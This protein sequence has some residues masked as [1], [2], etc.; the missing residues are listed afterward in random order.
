MRVL[1]AI[2]LFCLTLLVLGMQCRVKCIV[3]PHSDV[4]A[5]HPPG[6]PLHKQQVPA[7]ASPEGK[8]CSHAPQWDLDD[9]KMVA[10]LPDSRPC[11]TFARLG[12]VADLSL[13][14]ASFTPPIQTNLRI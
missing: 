10:V 12:P 5:K 13:P 3:I 7:D 11:V 8:Q 4:A 9:V 6:C 1:R 2:S 14:F